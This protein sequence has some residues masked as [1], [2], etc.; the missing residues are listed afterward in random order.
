[1]RGKTVFEGKQQPWYW[2]QKKEAEIKLGYTFVLAMFPGEIGYIFLIGSN[3][4]KILKWSYL[5]IYFV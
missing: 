3:K 4:H 2:Q 5:R 1:M